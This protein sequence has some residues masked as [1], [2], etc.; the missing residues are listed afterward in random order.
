MTSSSFAAFVKLEGESPDGAKVLKVFDVK[1]KTLEAV[2]K[3]VGAG[4]A[5]IASMV[6]PAG[7]KLFTDKVVACL[8][9][10]AKPRNTDASIAESAANTVRNAVTASATL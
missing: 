4:R 7:E 1:E 8:S 6:G 9:S 10:P 3:H 5:F 2:D